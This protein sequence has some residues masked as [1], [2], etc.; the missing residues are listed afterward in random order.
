[1]STATLSS[2]ALKDN[3][4]ILLIVVTSKVPRQALTATALDKHPVSNF[5]FKIIKVF[6]IIIANDKIQYN[7]I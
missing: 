3:K 5:V 2:K 1:M 7:P 6:D 4:Y